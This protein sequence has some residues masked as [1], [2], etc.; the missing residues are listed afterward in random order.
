M[1]NCFFCT[2]TRI[3]SEIVL[4]DSITDISEELEASKTSEF[5]IDEEEIETDYEKYILTLNLNDVYE[6]TEKLTLVFITTVGYSI[7]LAMI[8]NLFRT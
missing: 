3:P 1:K 6:N 4:N 5:Y 7:I 8:Y 2:N